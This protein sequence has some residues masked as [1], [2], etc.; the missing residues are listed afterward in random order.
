MQKLAL[1]AVIGALVAVVCNASESGACRIEA[2]RWR[3][4]SGD[5]LEKVRRN[6]RPASVVCGRPSKI[7]RRIAISMTVVCHGVGRLRRFLGSHELAVLPESFFDMAVWVGHF[8]VAVR[9]FG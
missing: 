5:R 3:G 1:L 4:A 9:Q 7:V 2:G 6:N 8:A